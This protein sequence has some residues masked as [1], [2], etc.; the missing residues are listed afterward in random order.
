ML[1]LHAFLFKHSTDTRCLSSIYFHEQISGKTKKKTAKVGFCWHS[2]LWSSGNLLV[3]D[4]TLDLAYLPDSNMQQ[5]CN[6][7]HVAW[8]LFGTR[9]THHSALI[10]DQNLASPGT[11]SHWHRKAD[12]VAVPLHPVEEKMSFWVAR[13]RT[14]QISAICQFEIWFE[15][16]KMA[17][18]E[19][20][21]QAVLP[22]FLFAFREKRGYFC[23]VFIRNLGCICNWRGP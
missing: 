8:I 17:H 13:S 2:P 21:Q 14:F 5:Q 15:Y 6:T 16:P 1:I 9:V 22:F 19:S 3:L 12:A 23:Y 11:S 10:S 7:L 18:A 4:P 20:S